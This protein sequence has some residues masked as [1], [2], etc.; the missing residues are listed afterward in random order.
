MPQVHFK[1]PSRRRQRLLQLLE[2]PLVRGIV[3]EP[4]LATADSVSISGPTR[5]IWWLR[6]TWSDLPTCNCRIVH[7]D[8]H[9]LRLALCALLLRS[10]VR[11]LNLGRLFGFAACLGGAGLFR[12]D[13]G[14]RHYQ[15]SNRHASTSGN[16][17]HGQPP[18]TSSA[19]PR[20]KL[21]YT[22]PLI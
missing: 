10:K 5:P 4:L 16:A 18:V 14:G 15:N 19:R 7:F 17:Q 11:L 9:I 12:R 6:L 20:P 21:P 8:S 13:L 3:A 22:M 1:T 2:Q